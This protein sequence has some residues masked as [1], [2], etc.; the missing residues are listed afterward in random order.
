MCLKYK[1]HEGKLHCRILCTDNVIISTNE[2]WKSVEFLFK[3]THFLCKSFLFFFRCTYSFHS[4]VTSFPCDTD[5]NHWLAF[6]MVSSSL[7]FSN[8][9]YCYTQ[10]IIKYCRECEYSIVFLTVS[11]FLVQFSKKNLNEH[12]AIQIDLH[13]FASSV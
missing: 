1:L 3:A 9:V 11:G 10:I 2:I 4:P 5:L 8:C 7:L 12:T 6:T 13:R